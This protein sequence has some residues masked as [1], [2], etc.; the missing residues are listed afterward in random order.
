MTVARYL[1]RLGHA[2]EWAG[3]QA[4]GFMISRKEYD[5]VPDRDWQGVRVRTTRDLRNGMVKISRGA[6]AT[7]TRKFSGFEIEVEPCPR[8]KVGARVTRVP[9]DALERVGGR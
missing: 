8:C 7:I 6:I 2:P 9:P 5:R 3:A 1:S 4:E